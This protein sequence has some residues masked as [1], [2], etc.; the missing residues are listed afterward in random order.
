MDTK[1]INDVWKTAKTKKLIR[2]SPC[3]LYKNCILDSGVNYFILALEKI[4]CQTYYSCEGHF[5]KRPCIP[6]FYIAFKASKRNIQKIK[7]T[8]FRPCYLENYKKNHYVLRISF[9]NLKEKNKILSHLAQI[10]EEQL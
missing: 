4:G 8:L 7:K 1:H 9:K 10:W 2:T 6:E 5:K 3:K